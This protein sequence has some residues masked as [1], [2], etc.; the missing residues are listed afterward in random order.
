VS[1][2]LVVA[3]D[4]ANPHLSPYQEFQQFKRHPLVA[5]TIQGGTCLQY[6]ARTLNEGAAC[7]NV[8]PFR[9]SS[10]AWW[11]NTVSNV[12]SRKPSVHFNKLSLASLGLGNYCAFTPLLCPAGGAQ[13]IPEL[14][15]PGG[16]LIGC[17]AGFL[18][19]PKIKGSH[20]AM[21]SGI[22]AGEEAFRALGMADDAGRKVRLH[23]WQQ[24]SLQLASP[25][26]D[27]AC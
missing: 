2:G 15:F 25:E 8:M 11:C 12:A 24:H 10:A 23:G 7:S 22:V 16:A 14:A 20:T 9:G 21:K 19:V 3:L 27:R 5:Q 4:Y 18:N 6:G 17:S 26:V 13:S 1:L